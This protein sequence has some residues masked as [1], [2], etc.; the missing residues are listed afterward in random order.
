MLQHEVGGEPLHAGLHRHP[1]L[2]PDLPDEFNKWLGTIDGQWGVFNP[3]KPE[4][5]QRNVAKAVGSWDELA[6][7]GEGRQV[8]FRYL[9]PTPELR[10]RV[11]A[12]MLAGTPKFRHMR[13]YDHHQLRV[14]VCEGPAMLAWV[15]IFHPEPTTRRQQQMLHKLVPALRWRFSAEQRLAD[16]PFYLAGLEALL[17]RVG[18]PAFVLSP[19]GR[20]ELASSAGQC[21]L[22][23]RGR[24]IR[25]ALSEA[26]LH[27]ERCTD[28]ELLPL[29]PH[30]ARATSSPS[31]RPLPRR[32]ELEARLHGVAQRFALTPRETEVLAHVVEG[33]SNKI[34]AAHLDCAERT[35]EVHVTHLLEKL[36]ADSRT[37]LAARVWQ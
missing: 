19:R 11:R 16:G 12:N 13:I 37:G 3:L 26:V 24:E 4:P 14:L 1:R 35:V 22:A 15:G 28:F 7:S 32:D 18:A 17:E 33:E 30:G 5:F 21:R 2:A 20:V 25:G 31:P 10:L 27:P 6:R 36:D 8:G 23:E 34:I 29:A 9:K